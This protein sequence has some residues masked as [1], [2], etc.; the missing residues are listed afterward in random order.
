MIY[1][2]SP[3]TDPDPWVMEW[4]YLQAAKALTK[5]LQDKRWAY[6]PIVHCHELAKIATLPK[7]AAFWRSYDFAMLARSSRFVI[8]TLEHWTDSIGVNLE[9]R[10]AFRLGLP[11]E[12]LAPC[13]TEFF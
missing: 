11:I 9:M 5:L 6:S 2:A 1:L 8:L 10:E 12:E 13:F 4:R 7:D 3:Y